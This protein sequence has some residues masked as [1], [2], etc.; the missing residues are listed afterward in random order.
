MWA[1]SRGLR[2]ILILMIM[3]G[4]L[5]VPVAYSQIQQGGSLAFTENTNITISLA[6]LVQIILTGISI[7][8]FIRSTQYNKEMIKKLFEKTDSLKRTDEKIMFKFQE[9][10]KEFSARHML[11]ECERICSGL[12]EQLA[13]CESCQR[14][15]KWRTQEP[16]E[17]QRKNGSSH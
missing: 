16:S 6:I 7:G 3:L 11:P 14:D 8:M 15:C 5:F 13:E 4:I 12:K 1:D 17:F 10:D 2:T 9:F